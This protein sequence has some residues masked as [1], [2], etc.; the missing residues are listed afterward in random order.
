MRLR[1]RLIPCIA[2]GAQVPGLPNALSRGTDRSGDA[3]KVQAQRRIE[4]Q[5]QDRSA[6][7]STAARGVAT[8][9]I[10][11]AGRSTGKG[12]AGVM[13]IQKSREERI[14]A[15]ID[16]MPKGKRFLAADIAQ[17]MGRV[18]TKDVAMIIRGQDNIKKVGQSTG[19]KT[20]W[21]KL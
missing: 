14:M 18:T 6:I 15:A 9:G 19:R 5:P 12:G 21:E 20:I 11:L 4:R 1:A 8:A 10:A 3:G 13:T 7:Q 16:H 17:K 2:T